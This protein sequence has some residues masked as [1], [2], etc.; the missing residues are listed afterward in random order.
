[1]RDQEIIAGCVFPGI[2]EVSAIE[3]SLRTSYTRWMQPHLTSIAEQLPHDIAIAVVQGEPDEHHGVV[4]QLISYAYSCVIYDELKNIIGTPRVISGYSMGI[5]SALYASG[6]ISFLRGLCLLYELN[7]LIDSLCAD[8]KY[9]MAVCVGV[10]KE[11]MAVELAEV[12]GVDIVNDNAP[13]T[14]VLSGYA[15]GIEEVETWSEKL[16]MHFFKRLRTNKPYHSRHLRKGLEKWTAIVHSHR[17]ADPE[18]PILSATSGEVLTNRWD[19]RDETRLNFCSPFSWLNVLR[20]L[21]RWSIHDLYDCGL[22]GSMAKLGKYSGVAHRYHLP[23][24]FIRDESH[25]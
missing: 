14:L 13:G 25:A 15:Q 18:I 16:G 8:H 2:V 6:S 1:M 24:R 17:F 7:S 10:E 23:K 22:G 11:K 9:G 20:T 12:E 21:K 4:A 3:K 19:C 5:F